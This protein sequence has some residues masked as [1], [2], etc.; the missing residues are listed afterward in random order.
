MSYIPYLGSLASLFAMGVFVANILI[1]YSVHRDAQA[2]DA[3]AT[4]RLMMFSPGG[5]AVVCLF[6]SV[7]ALA[8]YWLMHH[9]TLSRR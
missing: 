9:S 6:C 7:P 5:W 1:A 4:K 3:G 8:V 2:L